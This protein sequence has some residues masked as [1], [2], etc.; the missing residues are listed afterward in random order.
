MRLL[1]SILPL[2]LLL[3]TSCS[4]NV[5]DENTEY[6]NW[7]QRNTAFF[8]QKMT[9]AKAAVATARSQYGDAWEQHCNYRMYR[10]FSVTD[11]TDPAKVDSICVEVVENGTG[12]GSPLFTDSV[13]VNY[14]RT[15][16]PT[17]EHPTGY[18]LEHS[19]Y[20]VNPNDIFNA[21]SAPTI[22]RYV[23]AGISG[24]TTIGE[25]TALQHMHIGDRWR[26]FIPARLAYGDSGTTTIPAGSTLVVEMRLCEYHRKK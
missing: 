7:E 25:S 14:L 15:L 24:T 21:A 16:M 23:W 12:S 2:F 26:I 22:G 3:L 8:R 5:N 1:L 18:I 4:E 10:S 19:G 17:D 11:D 20:S 13:R 6:R 9:E